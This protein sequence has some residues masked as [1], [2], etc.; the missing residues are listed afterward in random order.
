M[1]CQ[2]HDRGHNCNAPS[3]IVVVWEPEFCPDPYETPRVEHLCALHFTFARDD[4]NHYAI[5]RPSNEGPHPAFAKV[6]LL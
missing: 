5:T 1:T 6:V 2:G 4:V 3:Q